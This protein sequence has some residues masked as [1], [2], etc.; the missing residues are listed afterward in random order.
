MS[1]LSWTNPKDALI[2]PHGQKVCMQQC[3]T[4]ELKCPETFVSSIY[5][6]NEK[7][8]EGLVEL[9][10]DSGKSTRACVSGAV[11]RGVRL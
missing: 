8:I 7:E 11:R 10:H 3:G 9:I 4:S 1:V 2:N 5:C 6:A